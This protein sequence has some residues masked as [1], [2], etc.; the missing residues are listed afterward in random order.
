MS[1][2]RLFS[3]FR[4]EAKGVDRQLIKVKKKQTSH[5]L[6]QNQN[7]KNRNIVKMGKTIWS[8]IFYFTFYGKQQLKWKAR[9]RS[10]VS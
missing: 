4:K 9:T 3:N 6:E 1:N 7:P 10:T 8:D 5:S 2:L